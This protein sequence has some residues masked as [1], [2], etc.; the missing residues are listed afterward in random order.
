MINY[1]IAELMRDYFRTYWEVVFSTYLG[2][3]VMREEQHYHR[4]VKWCIQEANK[5]Y[6][7]ENKKIQMTKKLENWFF[8]C[9]AVYWYK[10]PLKD[11]KVKIK[12]QNAFD[13]LVFNK[14]KVN[15]STDFIEVYNQF[16]ESLIH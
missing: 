12:V 5:V 2:D 9:T 6:L 11:A 7:L 3:D 16:I 14:L 13:E 1:R 8:N 15:S 4:H 10:L